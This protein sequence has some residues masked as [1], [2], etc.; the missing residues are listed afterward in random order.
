LNSR[1]SFNDVNSYNINTGVWKKNIETKGESTQRRSFAAFCL[2]DNGLF[3]HGGYSGSNRTS[4]NSMSLLNLG[5]QLIRYTHVV[6]SNSE[7]KRCA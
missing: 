3:I 2:M 6:R 7:S 4:F 5:K 1:L